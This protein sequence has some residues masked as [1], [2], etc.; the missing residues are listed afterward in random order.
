MGKHPQ[1]SYAT[2]VCAIQSEWIFLHHGKKNVGDTFVGVKNMLQKTFLTCLSFGKSKFLT[3]IVVTLS[4][5]M[6]NK[7]VL[8]L[9]NPV[10]SANENI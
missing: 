5:I 7:Y 3:L 8:V 10:T 1:V 2:V 9:L 6:V 4:N